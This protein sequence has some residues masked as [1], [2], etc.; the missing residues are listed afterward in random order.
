M[1]SQR[2]ISREINAFHLALNKTFLKTLPAFNDV[3]F[4]VLQGVEF[5]QIICHCKVSVHTEHAKTE[6]AV[7]GVYW[8]QL[9]S[10]LAPTSS[11]IPQHNGI[12]P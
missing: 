5:V 1:A 6:V 10:F 3:D 4:W 2:C 9:L 11:K 12:F 7:V 8:A